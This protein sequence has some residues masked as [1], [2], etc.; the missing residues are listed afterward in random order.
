MRI[1]HNITRILEATHSFIHIH[2]NSI[3]FVEQLVRPFGKQRFAILLILSGIFTVACTSPVE[4]NNT[5]IKIPQISS[6][7]FVT[8]KQIVEIKGMKFNPAT[9]LAGIGDTI[10]FVNKDLVPHNVTDRENSDTLSPQIDPNNKW[11]LIVSKNLNFYCSLHPNMEGN[12]E[13]ET[14]KN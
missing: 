2:F 1:I 4:E 11:M 5:D 13:L 3:H 10:L 8:T 6:P 9:I 7:A 12:I 14:A